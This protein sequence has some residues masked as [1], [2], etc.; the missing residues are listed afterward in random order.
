MKRVD[1]SLCSYHSK[2]LYHERQ[3][4]E[5]SEEKVPSLIFTYSVLTSLVAISGPGL[6]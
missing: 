3:T 4:N 6:L 5:D 1:F 2:I